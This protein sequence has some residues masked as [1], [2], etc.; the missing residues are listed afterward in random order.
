MFLFAWVGA[1]VFGFLGLLIMV[2]SL[3]SSYVA[4][5]RRSGSREEAN[6]VLVLGTSFVSFLTV[7]LAQPVLFIRYG[8]V[9]AALFVALRTIQRRPEQATRTELA[10]N[11]AP[12]LNMPA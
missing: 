8:W 6:L 4:A 10:A 7:T 1:G 3:A 11:Q 12:S 5:Y 2:V 9:P